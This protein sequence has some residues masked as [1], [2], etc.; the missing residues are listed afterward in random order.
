[1]QR[2]TFWHRAHLC[3]L[4][5]T[6]GNSTDPVEQHLVDMSY[7]QACFFIILLTLIQILHSKTPSP[8][9]LVKTR[10]DLQIESTGSLGHDVQ[11]WSVTVVHAVNVSTT[12]RR[13]ELRRRRYRHFADATQ[14]NSTSSWVEL[15]CVAINGPL[16]IKCC[17]WSDF[18]CRRTI[19]FSLSL[20]LA[21]KT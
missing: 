12:R 17:C 8:G 15:S 6:I 16:L 20:T 13:V 3:Q 9:K 1:M 21:H 19:T 14:L 4:S 10:H 2:L 18:G 5:P 7:K 11:N